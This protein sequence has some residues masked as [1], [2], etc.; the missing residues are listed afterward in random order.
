MTT[1]DSRHLRNLAAQRNFY[2]GTA[3]HTGAFA[4]NELIYH[5]VLHREFNVLVAENMMKFGELS[6]SANTYDWTR[7]DALIA[8][9]EKHG[10]K[11][12][13][14]TLVWHQQ[15]PKWLTSATWTTKAVQQL[16]EQHIKAVVERYQGRIWAWDVVNEAIADTGGYRTDSFWYQHLGPDYIALAFR[17]AHAADPNAI[18]Y[19]NDYEAEGMSPKSDAIYALVRDLKQ[20]GIPIHG[21]GWQ[22]HVSEGWRVTDE[23]HQNAA[24]LRALGLELS[25]TE[26]EVRCATPASAAQLDS[27]AISYR[28]AVEFALATSAAL[29]MWGFTDKYSWIPSFRPGYGAALPF[30]AAYQPKPAYFAI[31]DALAGINQDA[32]Q[33][34]ASETDGTA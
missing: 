8:Y 4:S 12:R 19:Y 23:H 33:A 3:V 16:L 11:V 31:R 32:H 20:S 6:R 18:L 15:L 13:G 7:S 29:V 5:D 14:H 9:A 28:D 24:R 27:Q 2:I 26:M 34:E 22:M 30:D 25:M 10:M 1:N 17:A 21:I